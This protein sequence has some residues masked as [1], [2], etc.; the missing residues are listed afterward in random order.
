MLQLDFV[1]VTGHSSWP[2]I[3]ERKPPLES[4]VDY[5]TDGF[6]KLENGWNR[7]VNTID[8]YNKPGQFVC[9][10]SYE[11]HSMADGDYTVYFKNH[12]Q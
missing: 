2:D 6:D 11:I 4:V 5:H 1:S 8:Q 3:P 9:F 10:P 12:N 7:F